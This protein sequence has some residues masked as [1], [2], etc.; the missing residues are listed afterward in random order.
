[1]DVLGNGHGI[2][3]FLVS[4]LFGARS[5][6]IVRWKT[7]CPVTVLDTGVHCTLVLHDLRARLL[8]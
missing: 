5:L 1:M 7:F 8:Y 2:F 4:A 6:V 3:E